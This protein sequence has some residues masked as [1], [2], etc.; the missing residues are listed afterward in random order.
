MARFHFDG[1]AAVL[2]LP[3]DDIELLDSLVEQLVGLVSDGLPAPAAPA[4]PADPFAQWEAELGEPTEAPEV[5][6]DPALQRLFPNPYPHDER[7]AAE[8]RRFTAAHGRTR[9]LDDA[10]TVR[11]ALAAAPPL[12]VPVGEVDAWLKTLN[13]LRL[14]I[15][16]R[17]GID[18]DES[19]ERLGEAA[20]DD[21]RAMGAYLLNLLAELQIVIIELTTPGD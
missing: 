17:L 12:R 20:D 3:H 2:Y 11:R 5:P 6:E 19:M 4:D 13:A 8:H 9:K 16:A 18:D 15:A 21:P 14:V 1:E 10:E 7:A